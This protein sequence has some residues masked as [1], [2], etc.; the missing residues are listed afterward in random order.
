MARYIG[1]D[2]GGTNT[3]ICLID[4]YKKILKFTEVSTFAK[5]RRKKD[6]LDNLTENIDKFFSKS[7]KGIGLGF[8]CAVMDPKKALTNFPNM[9]FKTLDV[10][11]I[12]K[13]K[14][15][16]NIILENDSNCYM[17]GEVN[18]GA[19]K[20]KNYVF[21]IT[22]G[23]GIGG[24]IIIRGNL[25]RGRG[26]AGEVGHMTIKYDGPKSYCGNHCF[27]EIVAKRGIMRLAR[28]HGLK[29]SEPKD[30]QVMAK[31]G[32]KTALKAFKEYG[33]LLGVGVT[34]MI[35]CFDPDIFIIG[36]NISNA[37]PF[38]GPMLKK[39]IKDRSYLRACPVVKAKL[40]QKAAALGAASLF[41]KY[42]R[43]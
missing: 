12:L 36:G 26:G 32:N 28:A 15:N 11:P 4:Q 34:N 6:F 20:G 40:G 27:E 13:R 43:Y 29:I 17:L 22:I 16:V 5:G 39:T 8:P 38:F 37:F 41:F 42:P 33:F 3:K 2:V 31:A 30:M 23:T 25:Y 35:N 1:V 19:A 7:V 9:P 10:Y 18:F 14:Y 24:G 21:G